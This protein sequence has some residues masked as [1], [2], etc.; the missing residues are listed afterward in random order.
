M[1]NIK[2]TLSGNTG[3]GKTGIALLIKD[4]LAKHG[5]DIEIHDT[6]SIPVNILRETREEQLASLKESFKDRKIILDI[7]HTKYTHKFE[8]KIP[9]AKEYIHVE[10]TFEEILKKLSSLPLS[11][12]FSYV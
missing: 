8:S 4:T 2:I 10:P 9:I 12:G 11:F 3:S 6:E 5:I 1:R 7:F